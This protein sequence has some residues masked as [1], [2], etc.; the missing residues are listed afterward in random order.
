MLAPV[1]ATGC[2]AVVV[3][4]AERPLP[5]VTLSEV[6]ATSDVPG[7]AVNVLT[8]RASELGSWLASH[9]DVNAIDPTGAD[10]ADRVELAREAAGTV[11]RMLDV[12]DEE[13]DW[14]RR[15]GLGRLR[16]YLEPKTVWHPMG[17]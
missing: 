15:P 4:S 12:P 16:T 2:T 6:L 1:L 11:K 3:S 5:A 9:E 17:V 8:G 14:T 13:P 10:S 7:G